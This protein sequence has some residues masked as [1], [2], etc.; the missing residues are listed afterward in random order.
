MKTSHKKAL[1][2]IMIIALVSIANFFFPFIFNNNKH[3]ILL[4]LMLVLLYLLLGIDIR[5][6]SNNRV[7]IRNIL[8]YVIIYYLIVYLL[9]LLTGFVR[10]VYTYTI[11]NLVMNII[12]SIMTIF[13][14]ELL[15]NQLINKTN[16]KKLILVLSCIVFIVFEISISFYAYDLSIKDQLYKFIGLF[17]LTSITKNILM[18]VIAMKTDY[19]P[20]IVYRLLMET[21]E[22]VLLIQPDLGP[23]LKSVI[24]IMVP[25]LVALMLI[26]MNKRIKETPEKVKK[27][28][29]LY[30][31]L[32]IILSILV[33]LN[34]GLLKY[35]TLVIGSESMLPIIAKGD[36]V[37]IE[38][39]KNTEKDKVQ[40]GEVLVYKYDGKIICH[41]VT[42]VLKRDNGVFYKTKG[43]NNEN[44]DKIVISREQVIGKVLF[45]IKYIGL[46]SVWL[47]ELFD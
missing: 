27:N 15:R 1:S 37:L 6:K 7:I 35:Q 31:I 40:I 33:L 47:N 12:P 18:T 43:D 32:V 20:A 22:F 29:K 3:L 11:S 9:G 14:V 8:I 10:T 17:V 34:S 36:V 28:S 4:G 41:R 26:N 16:K 25:V 42:N 19:L 38:R 45:Q 39:L 30:F 46:P 2:V 21:L 13:A 24:L 44:V 5:G 23:Y